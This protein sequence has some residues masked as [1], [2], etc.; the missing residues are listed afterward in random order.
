M[1]RVFIRDALLLAVS[2]A[3]FAAVSGAEAKSDAPTLNERARGPRLVFTSNRDGDEDVYA[4]DPSGHA[5][6]L[7][8]NRARDNE[9]V[10]A[11]NG[12]WL[13]VQREFSDLVLISGDGRRERRRADATPVAFSPNSR[14]LVF[15][16]GLDD[17]RM[18][19]VAVPR[20]KPRALGNGYPTAFSL[21]SGRTLEAFSPSG[22]LLAFSTESDALGVVDVVTGRR[23]IVPR[24]HF[25]DFVGWSPDG[26]HI[27]LLRSKEKG[28][29]RIETLLV[30]DVRRLSSPPLELVRSGEGLQAEWLTATRI[31]FERSLASGGGCEVGTVSATGG[32]P[33]IVARGCFSTAWSARAN[34]VAYLRAV[35]EG[36]SELVLARSDGGER[37]VVFQGPNLSIEWSPKGRWLAVT[38]DNG[39]NDELFV[40][41]ADGRRRTRLARG[42]FGLLESGSW[43]PDERYLSLAIEGG[44]GVASVNPPR[45]RRVWRGTIGCCAG[46]RWVAGPLP[47]KGTPAAPAPRPE[48]AAPRLL[49]SRG[50]VF[51]IASD[52]SRVAALLGESRVDCDH[53]VA[54]SKGTRRVI[55]FSRPEPCS[56]YRTYDFA[57]TLDGR[58]I[59]WKNFYCGNDCYVGG[60]NADVER[61]FHYLCGEGDV[62]VPRRP[63]RPAPPAETRRGVSIVTSGG[64]IR[65]RRE[66][67]G[68]T[69]TIRPPGGLVDAELE[70]TGL[71]Y[72]FNLRHRAMLGRIAFIPFTSL[73]G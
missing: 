51:E 7:T 20:G 37:K 52:G 27:A 19:V 46:A 61:P 42:N 71:F 44:L 59:V 66:Q 15:S 64:T 5:V 41:S 39:N 43:S 4:A 48:V 29:E 73:F 69:R 6:A 33:R 49:L 18:Y 57:L 28:D 3:A 53:L 26:K 60:C 56:D 62:E 9:L 8:R 21:L 11:K 45:M 16:R 70:D 35:S 23:R 38:T 30:A 22:R 72:A 14:L 34:R 1:S 54:W 24:S 31:G 2:V 25:R 55:R 65:L 50:R 47:P 63:P 32:S 17:D 67:D 58:K 36:T 13:A 68:R 40:V 12:K 10:L